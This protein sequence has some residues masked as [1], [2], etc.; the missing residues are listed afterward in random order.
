MKEL[1][2]DIDGQCYGKD[3][4]FRGGDPGL[5]LVRVPLKSSV[6]SFDVRCCDSQ[7]YRQEHQRMEDT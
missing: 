5:L 2:G 1:S 3:T 6:Q 4:S 7:N